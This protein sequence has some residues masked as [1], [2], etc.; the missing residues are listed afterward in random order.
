MSSTA[1]LHNHPLIELSF[2]LKHS[3]RADISLLAYTAL[4]VS[5]SGVRRSPRKGLLTFEKV[6]LCGSEA[7]AVGALHE[8]LE[9]AHNELV[10]AQYSAQIAHRNTDIVTTTR[11]AISNL[12]SDEMLNLQSG[13]NLFLTI[14]A[15]L[16]TECMDILEWL[17]NQK[18]HQNPSPPPPPC[19]ESYLTDGSTLY[20]SLAGA[21]D[22]YV[23]GLESSCFADQS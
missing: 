22:I 23:E 2:Q 11:T 16:R 5:A 4:K 12:V 15:T 20:S 6:V 1:H 3:S 8:H 21:L 19:V 17:E 10:H 7:T 18:K 13:L 14:W 9:G